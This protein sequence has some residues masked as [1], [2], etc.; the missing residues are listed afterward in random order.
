[1]LLVACVPVG[2]SSALLAED[3]RELRVT[4]TQDYFWPTSKAVTGSDGEQHMIDVF[5]L[6]TAMV[7]SRFDGKP[8]HHEDEL[9]SRTAAQRYCAA[10]GKRFPEGTAGRL[11]EGAWA[12][13]HVC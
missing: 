11:S 4:L 10:S 12:F 5:P 2:R 1:M 9:L 3:G 8:L 7:V 6:V 13:L